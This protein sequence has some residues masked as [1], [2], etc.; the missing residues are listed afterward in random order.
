M[1][2]TWLVRS[3]VFEVS[4]STTSSKL[5][6]FATSKSESC[7]PIAP[8]KLAA[9]ETSPPP[10]GKPSDH[11]VV[12]RSTSPTRS[13]PAPS[14]VT[15]TRPACDSAFRPNGSLYLTTTASLESISGLKAT[16]ALPAPSSSSPSL[17]TLSAMVAAGARTANREAGVGICEAG[18]NST[19]EEAGS[20]SRSEAGMRPGLCVYVKSGSSESSER[21]AG[22]SLAQEAYLPPT[23]EAGEERDAESDADS[24]DSCRPFVPQSAQQRRRRTAATDRRAVDLQRRGGRAQRLGT[25][26][27]DGGAALGRARPRGRPRRLQRRGGRVQRLGAQGHDRCSLHGITVNGVQVPGR[28][29]RPAYGPK[30]VPTVVP[31]GAV[32]ELSSEGSCSPQPRRPVYLLSLCLVCSKQTQGRRDTHSLLL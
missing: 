11:L 26:G 30:P 20:Q 4:A 31:E 19:A 2:V 24:V 27:H 5:R 9:V 23:L 3:S 25:Q 6:A 32:V 22:P 13:P 12:K 16:F 8:P 15:T 17:N 18:V 28:P 1:S 14:C 10:C 21:A 29:R 7:Q